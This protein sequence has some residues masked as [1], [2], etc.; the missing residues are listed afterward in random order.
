MRL[1]ADVHISPRTIQLLN[2]LGHDVIPV[3]SV[4]PADSQDEAI[5]LEAL[6]LGRA[7]LTQDLGFAAILVSAGATK[8]SLVTLRLSDARV[9]NVNARLQQVLP[10]LEDEVL[11]GAIAT[12]EDERVRTHRLP[13]K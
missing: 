8:P 6:E 7:I 1:I 11:A 9:D 12:V 2:D 4:L 13:V 10:S 3:E 5:V